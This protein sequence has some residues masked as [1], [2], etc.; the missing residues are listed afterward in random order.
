[1]LSPGSRYLITLWWR[2]KQVW[3]G[4][5]GGTID[6]QVDHLKNEGSAIGGGVLAVSATN[7]LAVFG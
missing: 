2:S 7:R 4:H 6:P 5:A 3:T 1:M